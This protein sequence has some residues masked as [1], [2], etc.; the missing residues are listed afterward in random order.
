MSGIVAHLTLNP[1]RPVRG[2]GGGG[3]QKVS[4][5]TLNVNNF[6]NFEAKTTKLSDFS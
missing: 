3:W 1:I 6:F 4:A 5:L 2:A